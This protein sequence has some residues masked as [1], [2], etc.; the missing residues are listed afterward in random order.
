MCYDECYKMSIEERKRFIMKLADDMAAC[1]TSI[2]SQGYESFLQ[3][4][5]RL[6]K[7]IQDVGNMAAENT[8]L[9]DSLTSLLKSKSELD[10]TNNPS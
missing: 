3:A 5:E 9:I 10:F 1:A 6:W 8:K 7:T 2:N 4:R